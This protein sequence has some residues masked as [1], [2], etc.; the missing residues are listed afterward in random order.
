MW[1]PFTQQK[2]D[3]TSILSNVS[4]FIG[5]HK[6]LCGSRTIWSLWNLI[7]ATSALITCGSDEYKNFVFM[8]SSDVWSYRISAWDYDIQTVLREIQCYVALMK[9]Y[10]PLLEMQFAKFH[11]IKPLNQQYPSSVWLR[12][13]RVFHKEAPTPCVLYENIKTVIYE[14]WD[15]QVVTWILGTYGCPV[16]PDRAIKG[17][18]NL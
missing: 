10:L 9:C 5:G 12:C 13:F 11:A 4:R 8:F 14:N 16:Q 2:H 15:E 6:L 17:S 1:I 3:H 18:I 7:Q